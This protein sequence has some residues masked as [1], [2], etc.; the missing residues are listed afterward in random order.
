VALEA[1]AVVAATG[2]R[3]DPTGFT[4]ALPGRLEMP[5]SERDTVITVDV[6]MARTQADPTA[7]G[8]RVLI[9]DE[10]GTYLPLGLADRIGA[11]GG[12]VE[13]YSQ[14]LF[15]G[16][17]PWEMHELVPTME[18]L[19]DLDVSCFPQHLVLEV[20][21]N[22]VSVRSLWGGKSRM[23]ADVDTVVLSMLR[24]PR[25][26]LFEKLEPLVS[27]LHLIGDALAP[28]APAD[29]IYD[30]EQIGRSL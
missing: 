8:N 4:T 20:G 9:I 26:E 27:E 3:W 2:A 7:L 1:D 29:A 30:G 22:A 5:G 10:S 13:I 11:A 19:A 23:V 14:R 12:H 25:R 18:R 6:A 16:E 24:T 28:R 21:A 15:I 17:D